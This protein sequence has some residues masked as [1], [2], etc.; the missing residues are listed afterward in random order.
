MADFQ[1]ISKVEDKRNVF[2]KI[3]D[4]L[5]SLQGLTFISLSIW[6]V[7]RYLNLYLGSNLLYTGY[8]NKIAILYW[9]FGVVTMSLALILL[10]TETKKSFNEGKPILLKLSL[11]FI[12]GLLLF[13]LYLTS[14]D[15]YNGLSAMN[16][17]GWWV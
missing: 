6:I 8:I 7:S 14:K 1:N 2:Q 3:I 16:F 17:M 11:I 4:F 13:G 5:F 15:L 12:I 9:T 10:Y